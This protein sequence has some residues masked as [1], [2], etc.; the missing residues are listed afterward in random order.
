MRIVQ[1]IDS[2]A[3]GGAERMAVNITE[4]L[5]SRGVK[6]ALCSLRSEGP[7]LAK[8]SP[9]TKFLSLGKKSSFDLNSFWRLRRWVILNDFNII[10]A[11]SSTIVWAV[12]LRISGVKV[13]IIWHDHFGGSDLNKGRIRKFVLNNLGRINGV[14]SVNARLYN[15]IQ[16]NRKHQKII[17]IENFP[18][19]DR[20]P[21]EIVKSDILVLANFRRQKDHFTFLKSL[22]VL[23]EKGFCPTFSLVGLDVDKEYR[24][25][26]NLFIQNKGL[27]KYCVFIGASTSPEKFLFGASVGLLSSKSE[28]LPVSLLEYGLAGIIPITTDVGD[29]ARVVG[30]NGYV[31]PSGDFEGMSKAIQEALNNRDR[32]VHAH[33]FQKRVNESF[34][35][36]NFLNLYLPFLKEVFND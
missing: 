9:N 34:G 23:K 1:F 28:G 33:K 25:E 32:N 14:I 6:T 15:W 4:A 10:H 35:A 18:S 19:L 16:A 3:L 20:S 30:S 36:N 27:S 7:L 24:D 17:Q 31:M 8:L 29:C 2:L 22:E 11:H 12:M 5:N 21:E 13:R 26:V